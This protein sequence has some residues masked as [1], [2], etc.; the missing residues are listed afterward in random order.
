MQLSDWPQGAPNACGTAL[1]LQRGPASDNHIRQHHPARRLRKNPKKKSVTY[2][3]PDRGDPALT[4]A[5]GTL[6][7]RPRYPHH[8]EMTYTDHASLIHGHFENAQ[9]YFVINESGNNGKHS[10]LFFSRGGSRRGAGEGFDF[11]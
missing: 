5:G 1:G 9:L 2:D 10:S 3:R 6:F 8:V 11:F 7:L 4:T